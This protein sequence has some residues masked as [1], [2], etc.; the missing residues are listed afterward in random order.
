M[1]E[2]NNNREQQ[3]AAIDAAIQPKT[4]RAVS[5]IMPVSVSDKLKRRAKTKGLHFRP[6]VG[7]L[8]LLGMKAEQKG[9]SHDD[10]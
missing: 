2:N 9:E 10:A 4:E 7:K 3:R 1:S 5:V 8:L 6:Y